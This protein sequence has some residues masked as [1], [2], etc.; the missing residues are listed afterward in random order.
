MARFELRVRPFVAKD[1]KSLPKQSILR[2][3][4]LIEG[5]REDPRPIGSEKLSGLE[6]YRIRQGRYRILYSIFDAE[7]VVEIVTVG[8][9]K[10]VYR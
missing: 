8:H 3:L 2:I 1:L 6:R 10:D 9:R 7:V 4:E 5:L